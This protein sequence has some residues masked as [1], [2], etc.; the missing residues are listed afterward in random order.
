M[1]PKAHLAS[2]SRMSGS[3]W[4]IIPSWLSGSWR[5]FLQAKQELWAVFCSPPSQAPLQDHLAH[6]WKELLQ[7]DK[8]RMDPTLRAQLVAWHQGPEVTQSTVWNPQL[9]DHRKSI[10]STSSWGTKRWLRVCVLESQ[11]KFELWLCQLKAVW[12]WTLFVTSLC[13]I[14]IVQKLGITASTSLRINE[15]LHV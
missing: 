7:S 2:H 3:R 1:L 11:S 15:T 12:P 5:S 4:V 9:S 6:V 14:L 13:L 10:S 8:D